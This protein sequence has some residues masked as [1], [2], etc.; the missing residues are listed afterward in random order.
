MAMSISIDPLVVAAGRQHDLPDIPP[1]TEA[2]LVRQSQHPRTDLTVQRYLAR[3]DETPVGY[4]ELQLP[5][6]DNLGNAT[7]ELRVHPAPRRR[8]AGRAFLG[9]AVG[10]IN[11]QIGF[12]AADSWVH[13]QM[14]C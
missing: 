1:M 7:L 13:W 14:T 2:D 8:R 12:R 4:L 9:F 5:R 6:H 10:R 3:L 11:R